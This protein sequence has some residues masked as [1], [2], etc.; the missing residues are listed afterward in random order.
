MQE[1]PEDKCLH[2][3]HYMSRKTTDAE[4]RYH[5]YELEALAIVRALEKIRIYLEGIKSEIF[6]DCATF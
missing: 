2:P 3:V 1:N 5:S 6:T 4:S